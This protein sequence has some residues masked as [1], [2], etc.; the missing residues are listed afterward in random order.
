MKR[1]S[2]IW[3]FVWF[4][5]LYHILYER[6][7]LHWNAL[8]M[9]ERI[10]NEMENYIWK[11]MEI[12]F[13]F[14]KM[15]FLSIKLCISILVGYNYVNCFFFFCKKWVKNDWWSKWPVKIEMYWTRA[16]RTSQTTYI[17][18][19]K[20]NESKTFLWEWFKNMSPVF[21]LCRYFLENLW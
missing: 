16:I 6:F 4:S 15:Y 17:W 10:S 18:K 8:K 9:L 21:L 11:S 19:I 20:I 1:I 2:Y 14:M 12:L 5:C 3:I 7:T 13:S